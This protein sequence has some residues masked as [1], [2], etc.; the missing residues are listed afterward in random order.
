MLENMSFRVLDE[1]TCHI[2]PGGAPTTGFTI[3]KSKARPV[4]PSILPRLEARPETRWSSWEKRRRVTAKTH[5]CWRRDWARASCFD[6]DHFAFLRRI[7]VPYSR[8]YMWA[9][10][11]KYPGIAVQIVS[12]S[13]RLRSASGRSAAQ[14]TTREA[15]IAAEIEAALQAVEGLDEDRILR[16]FVNAVTAAIRT[17]FYQLDGDGR[18]KALIAIKFSSR[19]VDGMPLPRPLYEIFLYSPRVEAVHLR[20]GKVARGGLRWS[21]RP[22]D[23][24][25]EI[26]GLVKAQQVKNAVIV[27][28]GAKGGFVPKFLPPVG[29]AKPSR[30]KESPPTKCSFPGCS[31]SPTIS[32]LERRRDPAVRWCATMATIPILWWPPTR[33]P[34]RSRTSPMTIAIEHDFWLGDAF[35]SGGSAGYDHKKMGITAR[36]AWES[37][38]RHFGKWTSTSRPRRS[39]PSAS[40]ICQATCSGTECCSRKPSSSSL[41]SIT[42]TFLSIPIPIRA[43]SWEERKRLYDLPRSSW[44]DYGRPLQA[45][46]GRRHLSAAAR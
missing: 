42:G 44:Q 29:R 46:E 11:R 32:E 26:L 8:D 43:A 6:P 24:R 40:A 10:L 14:R 30:R 33:A 45:F 41:P 20:F 19:K 31:T 18:A 37:V 16:R 7:R 9:T 25:T 13:K 15:A 39:P 3:W 12:S 17:N 35:A 2:R 22:Q 5:W 23:F 38:K 34:R 1:R 27:P 21:D 36:G 4:S 28:V